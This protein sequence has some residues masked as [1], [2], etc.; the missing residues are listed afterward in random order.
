MPFRGGTKE[1]FGFC[2]FAF[3]LLAFFLRAFFLAAVFFFGA[4][5][6][7]DAFA[8]RCAAARF[9]FFGLFAFALLRFIGSSQLIPASNTR[10]RRLYLSAQRMS[11]A[12]DGRLRLLV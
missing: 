4:F 3:F 11:S 1:S 5:F 12:V 2:A 9:V 7:A 6:F 10:C 8:T